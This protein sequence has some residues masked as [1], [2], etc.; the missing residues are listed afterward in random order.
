M[1]WFAAQQ[2]NST[3]KR[4]KF[5]FFYPKFSSEFSEL[6][7]KFQKQEEMA[8]KWLK[9]KQ[10]WKPHIC[11]IWGLR[12]KEPSAKLLKTFLKNNGNICFVVI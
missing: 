6:S 10:S 7:L 11:G 5:Y 1:Y 4:Q 9:L 2:Q 3:S 12:V 8:K